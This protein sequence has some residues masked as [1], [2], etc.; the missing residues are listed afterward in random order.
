MLEFL[1]NQDLLGA[2]QP[3]A[4]DLLAL[5]RRGYRSIVNLRHEAEPGFWLEEGQHAKSLGLTYLHLP[6]NREQAVTVEVA[7]GVS[8]ALS[9]LPTP[10]VLHCA[11][12]NRVGAVVALIRRFVDSKP[13]GDALREGEKAGLRS[14]RPA[15]EEALGQA[16]P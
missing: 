16:G 15:V 14:L 10:V 13:A 8:H 12:S 3:T 5:Q 4:A 6:V 7:K 2:G 9:R 1:V 11:S